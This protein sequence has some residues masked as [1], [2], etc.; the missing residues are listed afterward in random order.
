MSIQGFVLTETV[1]VNA[2]E[3][4]YL[5]NECQNIIILELSLPRCIQDL[6]NVLCSAVILFS[7]KNARFQK[8]ILCFVL[9]L[10]LALTYELNSEGLK[11]KATLDLLLSALLSEL[12]LKCT[13]VTDMATRTESHEVQLVILRLLSV[14]MSRTKMTGSKAS[15]EV[16]VQ[17][18]YYATVR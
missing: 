3:L 10:L 17:L 9:Q 7:L 1:L 13:D 18:T 2:F 8:K 6:W 15:S 5:C 11:D 14:L 16:S 12:N 4:I